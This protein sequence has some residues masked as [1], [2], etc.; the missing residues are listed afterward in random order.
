MTVNSLVLRISAWCVVLS[1]AVGV[2]IGGCAGTNG[3]AKKATGDPPAPTSDPSSLSAS[4]EEGRKLFDT[5][6]CMGCHTVHGQGGQVG[7]NLS[8]EGNSGRSDRWLA[9]QIR[10]PRRNDPG[11]IMPAYNNLTNRKVN[12]L[13]AYLKSLKTSES[14]NGDGAK[15]IART[16]ASRPSASAAS[17]SSAATTSGG[18]LWG[19]TCG[20][21]HNLRPPSEYSDAQWAVAVH[22]MRIR[23]PLTGEQQRSILEFLQASN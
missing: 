3:T 2:L 7:P 5:V 4:A 9:T 11:T 12:D 6:G 1:V 14:Q 22:H 20:Q 13:V 19:R 17:T 15:T 8:N 16:T 21:C 23:A 18:E 10:D